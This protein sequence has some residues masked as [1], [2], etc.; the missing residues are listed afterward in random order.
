MPI[1]R[2]WVAINF[3]IVGHLE[4]KLFRL[5]SSEIARGSGKTGQA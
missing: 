1:K 4:V 2:T 3:R 5:L